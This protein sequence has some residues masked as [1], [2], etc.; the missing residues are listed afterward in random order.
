MHR[1]NLLHCS[2]LMFT[3]LFVSAAQSEE[4]PIAQVGEVSISHKQVEAKAS[5]E[6][7][8]IEAEIYEVKKYA[9][10][11][12]IATTLLEEEA[13]SLDISLEEFLD[14]IDSQVPPV[15]EEA[16]AGYYEKNKERIPGEFEGVKERIQQYLVRRSKKE[17][18]DKVLK[19]LRKK[20]PVTIYMKPPRQEV[21][22]PENPLS[23]G[24]VGAPV[25]IVEFSDFQCPF[26]KKAAVLLTKLL[27]EYPGEIRIIYQDLPL[28]FIHPDAFNA[29]LAA[30]CANEQNAFWSY[31]DILFANQAA[32][33]IDSLKKYAAG[34]AL[35]TT[36]FNSCLDSKKYQKDIEKDMEAA[37]QY[38]FSGTPAFLINGRSVRGVLPFAAFQ[39]II[40]EELELNE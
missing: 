17:E 22:L 8:A 3:F 27:Q 21:E 13:R 15:T 7:S 37:D 40:D 38:G 32:L 26:C 14:R 6:L 2:L 35:D 28:T 33:D 18:M 25:T 12:L 5:K 4:G 11:E 10:K 31:H 20:Y 30:R 29:A 1:M 16:V 23:R 36:S 39:E 19:G 24:P 34:L 9:V